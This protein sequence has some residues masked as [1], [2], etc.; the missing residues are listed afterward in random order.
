VDGKCLAACVDGA[1]GTGFECK[2][3]FCHKVVSCFDRNACG[4][5]DCVDGA[6]TEL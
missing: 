6:C 1:C 2:V 3:G 5:A 4:G